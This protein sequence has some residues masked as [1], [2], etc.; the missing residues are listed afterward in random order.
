MRKNHR[1]QFFPDVIL[2]ETFEVT[3]LRIDNDNRI[4]WSVFL[5]SV[6]N[7]FPLSAVNKK[8]RL[9]FKHLDALIHKIDAMI[10][11]VR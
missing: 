10:S 3:K 8:S 6:L 7:D 11:S 2:Q 9:L 5:T 4:E 1:E